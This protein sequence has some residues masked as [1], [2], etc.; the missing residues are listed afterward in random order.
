MLEKK[1]AVLIVTYNRK[2]YLMNLLNSLKDQTK[3]IDSIY[4]VDNCSTDDTPQFL[5]NNKIIDDYKVSNITKSLWEGMTINYYRNNINSGGSGGFSLGIDLVL[6]N[7]GNYDYLWIMD[8]DV[9][10]QSDCLENLLLNVNDKYGVLIPNRSTKNFIDKPIQSFNWNNFLQSVT[11]KRYFNS[12][13]DVIEVVDMPFEGP[14][15]SID[16]LKNVGTSD[17]NYFILFDDSD[18]AQRCLKYTKIAYIRN[19]HLNRQI[20]LSN[21]VKYNF[22]WKNYYA[23]RNEIIFDKKYNKNKV[24]PYF[25]S[26]ILLVRNIFGAVKHMDLN[27]FKYSIKGFVDGHKQKTGKTVEPGSF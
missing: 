26:F 10:P 6:E 13:K 19:A 18:Y 1:I 3:K 22:S 20:I 15:I 2:Q 16:V 25:R 8:D 12:D 9:L 11:L 17:K 23:I 21:D 27:R 5:M 14:F 4:L 7:K 24:I